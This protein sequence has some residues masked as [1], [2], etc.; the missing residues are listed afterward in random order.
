[1]PLTQEQSEQFYSYFY[2]A[3]AQK[4][5]GAYKLALDVFEKCYEINPLD[6]GLCY[7]LGNLYAGF[8]QP[9]KAVPLLERAVAQ[10]PD[11]WWYSIQLLEVYLMTQQNENAFRLAEGFQTNFPYKE[12]TYRI[13]ETLYKQSKQYAKAIAAFDKLEKITSINENLSLEKSALYIELKQPKKAIA[14][15]EKLIKKYPS[16]SKY[17]IM[18]GD[19]YFQLKEKEKAFEIYNQILKE[20][21]ESPFVYMSLADY[22]NETDSAALAGEMIR[23]VLTME[24]LDVENK[25]LILGQYVQGFLQDTVRFDETESLFRLLIDRYPLEE[26]VHNYYAIFL[27]FRNRQS[28]AASALESAIAINPKNEN[29]WGQL[30]NIYMMERNFEKVVEL[31]S[32]AIENMP[33]HTPWYFFKGTAYFQLEDYENA[34]Q[35]N[36]H[37]LSLLDNKQ[38][39]MKSDFYAQIGDIYYK[40]Q[41][42]DEAFEA[43]ED[44]LKANPSNIYVMNNYAYYL[45]EE[46]M[47]LSKAE[48]MSAKTIEKEPS[49]STYLDTYAWIFYKQGNYTLAKFYIERAMSNLDDEEGNSVIMEHYGDILLAT[50]NEQKALEMWKKALE[51]GSDD[52]EE[53]KNKIYSIE[54]GKLKIEN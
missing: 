23:K 54:S 41:K 31:T 15:I 2:E 38:Q 34:L 52:S 16:V 43:F 20:D 25:I 27:Q 18:L 22:Y 44:A 21:P 46:N 45:S 6:A 3:I 30:L 47:E 17:K 13:L 11:N 12:E 51:E 50:G 7:E 39:A 53:L 37:A 36:L 19:T 14:E 28:E 35:T 33:E 10:Y 4:E 32:Q 40:M 1:M 24:T 49:N 5:A 26:H 29:S 8:Q 9:Q 42:R 48:R